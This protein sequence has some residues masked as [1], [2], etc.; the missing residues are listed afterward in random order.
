MNAIVLMSGG[1]DSTTVLA[2]AISEGY[3]VS[4]IS[5]DYGQRHRIELDASK[6]IAE[7]YGIKRRVFRI[8]LTQIGGSSITSNIDVEEGKIGRE[9]VPNTYVPA[10][11]I[12]FL[13]IAGAYADIENIDTIMIGVNAVDYSGYPDC[14]PEFISSMERSL[15]LGLSRRQNLKI[16]APLQKMSKAEIIGMGMKLKAPYELTRSCYEGGNKACGK[17]DSCLLRLKGFM[18]SGFT[19]PIEY[20]E[21]P[22]FYIQ[23][24]KEKKLK[25]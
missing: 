20:E 4:G 14:R 12:V 16:F 6:A 24:L 10:R 8:D 3:D 25:N 23:Y 21:Y 15:R 1:L 2:Y 22:E 19:D 5:F 18:E 7:H 17:C 9:E 11:N 13:S